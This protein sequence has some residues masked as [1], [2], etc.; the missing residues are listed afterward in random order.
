MR[1]DVSSAHGSI[2]PVPGDT[3]IAIDSDHDH[4]KPDGM[5]VCVH[6]VS[7]CDDLITLL[8][9]DATFGYQTGPEY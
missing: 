2:R 4:Q 9:E 1:A 6:F 7:D 5:P 8:H 3:R